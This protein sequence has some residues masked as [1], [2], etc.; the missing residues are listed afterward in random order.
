MPNLIYSPTTYDERLYRIVSGRQL[1]FRLR[2]CFSVMVRYTAIMAQREKSIK[3]ILLN[4]E[5]SRSFGRD[6]LT[7]IS[8]YLLENPGWSVSL[9]TH[10]LLESPSS[11]MLRWKGDGIITRTATQEQGELLYGK[12]VPL[13][14]LCGQGTTFVAEI[15][16][17]ERAA[18]ELVLQHFHSRGLEHF[19][20]FGY[21][22]AWWAV[23][24]A[25]ALRTALR[26]EFG[27]DELHVFPTLG[28]GIPTFYPVIERRDE[29]ILPTW[30]ADL[31]KP[32]GIWCVGDIQA[33]Q[34]LEV[35]QQLGLAIPDDVA[36]LG[37]T[38]DALLCCVLTPNLSSLEYDAAE[39]GYEAARRLNAKMRGKTF[40]SIAEIKPKGIVVRESTNV[41]HFQDASL[42]RAVRFIRENALDGISVHEVVRVTGLSRST[43]QRKFKQVLDTNPAK[44]ILRIRLEYAKRLLLETDASLETIA[45]KIGFA[46]TEYFVQAFRR[47]CGTTPARFRKKH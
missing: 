42:A 27:A 18:A 23:R 33:I 14:E 5:T 6:I 2:C 13:V 43:L 47:E 34:L 1:W 32:V 30:L 35:C 15:R 21:G 25:E 11:L 26:N 20:V 28:Q 12:G 31:P 36:I 37:T 4:I 29:L 16:T 17:D 45:T 8:R 9:E 22:N 10:G 44:E 46:T 3:S 41:M 38:N 40:R 39:V 24:R 7:G 19:A